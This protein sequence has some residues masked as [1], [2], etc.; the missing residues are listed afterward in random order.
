MS[1]LVRQWLILKALCARHSGETVRRLAAEMDVSDKTIR[2]DIKVFT[3]AGIPIL[4]DIGENGEKSYRLDP[5]AARADIAFTYDEALSLYLAAQ[6]FTPYSQTHVGTAM[7]NALKKVRASLGESALCYLERMRDAFG[8]TLFGVG[9]YA[10]KA[11]IIDQLTIGIEDSKVVFIAYQSQRATEPVTYDVHPY[12]ITRHKGSLYLLGYKP[13]DEAFR[14]W[15]IDRISAAEVDAFQF[16]RK[17]D[18]NLD[19]IFANSFGIYQQDAPPQAIQ[20][21]FS[22]SVTTYVM[23]YQWHPSQQ[24]TRQAD[25]SLIVEFSLSNTTELKSW[26]LSF[27][28]YVE[29]LAP[30]NF[31]TEIRCEI[32]QMTKIYT[33]SRPPQSQQKAANKET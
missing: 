9:D 30:E 6:H 11:D 15:K 12:R 27:G 18:H 24:A 14:T 1:T 25:G 16:Q 22:P 20:V 8:D 29:V 28:R 17:S 13:D 10:D 32:E 21:R 5:A 23:E 3:D 7:D 31:R 4:E 2:R 26:L 19:E 33:T